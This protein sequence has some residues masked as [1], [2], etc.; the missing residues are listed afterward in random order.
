[1]KAMRRCVVLT[2]YCAP[3]RLKMHQKV[4]RSWLANAT[5]DVYLVDA[6][7]TGI[8]D[9]WIEQHERFH[10]HVFCQESQ[11]SAAVCARELRTLG[12]TN[13]EKLSLQELFR[14][15]SRLDT[16]EYIFKLTCKYYFEDHTPLHAPYT[17]PLIFQQRHRNKWQNSEIWGARPRAMRQLV[18]TLPPRHLMERYLPKVRMAFHRLA[19]IPLQLSHPRKNGTTLL[20]L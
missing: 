15:V 4:T 7:G 10:Q 16:Y 19:A 6:Y 3:S 2:S 9:E 17:H 14:H 20:S 12:P 11:L 8:Q 5:L 1:M 18:D 13:L